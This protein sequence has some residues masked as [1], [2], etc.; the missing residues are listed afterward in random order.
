MNQGISATASGA[1]RKVPPLPPLYRIGKRL[2]HRIS[3]IIT[4]SSKVGDT[5]VY[6][7]RLFSWV[8]ALEARWPEIRGELDAL[9]A[10][11]AAI[12]PLAEISPD[13]RRIAPP[14]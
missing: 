14:D 5:P 3:A 6:D 2:R 1:E 7:P 8:P 9:L 13:H 10:L 12:P 11:E 4:R